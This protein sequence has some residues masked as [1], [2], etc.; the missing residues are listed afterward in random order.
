MK[1]RHVLVRQGHIKE[2]GSLIEDKTI[3]TSGKSFNYI[4]ENHFSFQ[5]EFDGI[6]W[7]EIEGTRIL[8]STNKTGEFSYEERPKD[9]MLMSNYIVTFNESGITGVVSAYGETL[10]VA[11]KDGKTYWISI[12][13]IIKSLMSD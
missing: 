1:T 3:A 7:N 11:F 13:S 8:H 9:K 12:E 6:N 4:P 5:E 10:E 2:D